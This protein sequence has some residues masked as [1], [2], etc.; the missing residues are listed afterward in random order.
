MD[1]LNMVANPTRHSLAGCSRK[2][3]EE[4]MQAQARPGQR[5]SGVFSAVPESSELRLNS[6]MA[7]HIRGKMR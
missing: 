1:R 7:I 2:N 4:I 6:L 3:I 5:E